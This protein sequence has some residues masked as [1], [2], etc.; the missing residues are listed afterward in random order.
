MSLRPCQ[1][2]TYLCGNEHDICD[3]YGLIS[4]LPP[5][6]AGDRQLYDGRVDV[7]AKSASRLRDNHPPQTIN[8]WMSQRRAI[9]LVS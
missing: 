1:S 8:E 4:V 9:L 2:V 7:K 3:A 6:L 5:V